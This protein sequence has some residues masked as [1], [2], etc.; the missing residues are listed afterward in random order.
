ME[1][2]RRDTDEAGN[3]G[4]GF[5]PTKRAVLLS[6]DESL[7]PS[8]VLRRSVCR[9]TF[10]ESAGQDIYRAEPFEA[11]RLEHRLASR[12]ETSICQ[13]GRQ[14]EEA[15][16][17][18]AG[19][20]VSHKRRWWQWTSRCPPTRREAGPAQTVVGGIRRAEAGSIPFPQRRC[21][22]RL[23]LDGGVAGGR[24]SGMRWQCRYKW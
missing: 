18:S 6:G 11:L 13:W 2:L 20:G 8:T 4:G 5:S 9:R 1:R 23:W 17:G 16:V 7:L 15:A 14:Q 19:R 24:L 21:L 22:G 12:A 3:N 10:W